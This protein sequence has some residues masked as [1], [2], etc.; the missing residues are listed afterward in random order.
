MLFFS[1]IC[2]AG[3]VRDFAVQPRPQKYF[4]SPFGRNS[5]IDFAIPPSQLRRIA[6]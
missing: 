1:L 2:P 4:A 5:F 6:P 3:T